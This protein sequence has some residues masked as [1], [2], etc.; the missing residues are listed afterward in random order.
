[1]SDINR[2][3]NMILTWVQV[4]ISESKFVAG[5]LS[6]YGITVLST[7]SVYVASKPRITSN[8]ERAPGVDDGLTQCLSHKQA[9]LGRV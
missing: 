2:N 8:S 6:S 1:M 3:C 9:K 7:Q 4:A 5:I